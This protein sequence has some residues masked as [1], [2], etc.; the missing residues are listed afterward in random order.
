MDTI[1]SIDRHEI[2]EMST[3]LKTKRGLSIMGRSSAMRIR[4]A[5]K[6]YLLCLLVLML[7]LTII[8]TKPKKMY[9]IMV[10][11]HNCNGKGMTERYEERIQGCEKCRGTG[12]GDFIHLGTGVSSKCP[13]CSGRTELVSVKQQCRICEGKMQVERVEWR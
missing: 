11:C 9:V 6:G 10:D 8:A 3:V 1:Y 2:K 13:H 7:C 4:P 5:A 12:Q